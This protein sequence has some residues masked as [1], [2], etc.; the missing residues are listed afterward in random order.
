MF[1]AGTDPNRIK[2]I[3]D[4]LAK[5]AATQE[6]KDYLADQYADA[7]SFVPADKARAFLEKELA[8]MKKFAIKK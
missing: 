1:K 7:T 2:V 5:A 6:F 3:S 4:A 8:S